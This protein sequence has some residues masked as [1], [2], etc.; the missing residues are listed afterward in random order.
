M[1]CQPAV[2]AATLA[3]GSEKTTAALLQ[4]TRFMSIATL[5]NALDLSLPVPS[6]F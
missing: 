1:G 5:C 2:S 6:V 4:I 3:L